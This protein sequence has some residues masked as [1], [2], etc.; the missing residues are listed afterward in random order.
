[1]EKEV[2]TI[3][4]LGG[5]GFI[6]TNLIKYIENNDLPYKV[7]VFDKFER[8]PCGVESNVIERIY[9]G[10]FMDCFVMEKVFEENH[11]D[12]VF[13]CL[14]S[15]VP[16]RA[17]NAKYDIESNLVPTV[18]VLDLMV[19]HGVKKIL[20]V[21]SGGAVYGGNE[22]KPHKE[23]DGLFPISPYGITKIAIEKYLFSYAT[24]YGMEPL[25]LR[26]S[27]PYGKYHFSTTQGIV[28]VALRAALHRRPFVVWGD[29]TARKDY[30]FIDDFCKIV[31]SLIQLNVHS[32]VFNVASGELLD[33]NTILNRIKELVPTFR[34]DYSDPAKLDIPS[35][36]LDTTRLQNVIGEQTFVS[37]EE[38]LG[39][40][41][42]WQV[43]NI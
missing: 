23:D 31:F 16:S 8:H 20:F 40:L 43:E 24:L 3:L 2:K 6:G 17:F 28:N 42:N 26:L 36:E 12:N 39:M 13:H 21:S 30:I 9:S 18:G 7:I 22:L 1:M 35:F 14:S 10:D 32:K 15:T 11:I 34:W 27:N 4:L 19:K 25:V 33:V 29:G 37:F 38:G 41:Y 5:F